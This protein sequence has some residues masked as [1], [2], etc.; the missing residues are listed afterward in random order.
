MSIKLSIGLTF[1]V[2]ALG[3]AT[4]H[5]EQ[6]TSAPSKQSHYDPRNFDGVWHL[7]EGG[8]FGPEAETG[9]VKYVVYPYTA[10]YQAIYDKRLADAAAGNPYQPAGTTCLPSGAIRLIHPRVDKIVNRLSFPISES[11]SARAAGHA[12]PEKPAPPPRPAAATADA[13]SPARNSW[14]V[15]AATVLSYAFASSWV[16]AIAFEGL[17]FVYLFRRRQAI[18]ALPAALLALFLIG[19][20]AAPW[21]FG[22]LWITC[23]M[24][25]WAAWDESVPATA[26]DLQ[27]I[28]AVFL[29]LL[30]AFQLPW[31]F[32]ALAYDARYPTSSDKAVA[33]YLHSLP[34]NTRMAGFGMSV[35]VQPYF[36]RN[37]F[38]NQ[39]ETFTLWDGEPPLMSLDETMA[40]R[41]D[42]VVADPFLAPRVEAA[43]YA[44]T[45]QFCGAIYLPNLYVRPGCTSILEP[46]PTPA[47]Q[48]GSATGDGR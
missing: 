44:V 5:G 23:L 6:P 43:G 46:I 22:L 28:V 34:P 16:P 25:L 10:E 33:A 26:V 35:G 15:T 39:S 1:A 21:H 47:K 48:P 3:L 32:H 20:Y 13:K 29:G 2:I 7:A 11:N 40:S 14:L 38:F 8:K 36:H 42:I 9:G 30:C 18:L 37:I 12:A 27:N 41:P 24:I 31:T 45:H 17:V 4:A 19:V